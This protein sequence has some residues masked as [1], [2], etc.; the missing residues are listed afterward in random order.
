MGRRS[1]AHREGR[2]ICVYWDFCLDYFVIYIFVVYISLR[3]DGHLTRI[4][5]SS[6][7]EMASPQDPDCRSYFGSTITNPLLFISRDFGTVFS[8]DNIG[9]GLVY[10]VLCNCWFV[11]LLNFNL[12]DYINRIT[13]S[14]SESTDNIEIDKVGEKQCVKQPK[15]RP[16]SLLTR[17]STPRVCSAI[18]YTLDL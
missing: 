17:I 11:G 4:K 13:M 2:R 15:F 10:G 7:Y 3:D 6:K 8:T 9:V 18:C 12:T 5:Q 16:V 1:T 14:P